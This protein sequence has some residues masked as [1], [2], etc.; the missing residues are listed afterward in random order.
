MK[1]VVLIWMM[2]L[3][4]VSMVAQKTYHIKNFGQTD[5][6][7]VRGSTC[8]LQFNGFMWVGTS[9]GLIGFDGKHTYVYTIPDKEG[10]GGYYS[11]VTA[12]AG[13]KGRRDRFWVGTKRG[14]YSFMLITQKMEPLV[15]QGAPKLASVTTMQFDA[16]GNLW[17]ILN[18]QAYMIDV[19][20][21]KASP[22]AEGLIAPSCL[23][24]TQNGT[25]WM[26]DNKGILYRYDSANRRLRSYNVKPEG[27]EKFER[28]NKITE[29]GNGKL[30]LLSANDGVCLF[31][32]EKF[33][34]KLLLTHDD[35]GTPITGHTAITPDGENLW[36]GSE[37]GIIIY[38]TK[39]GEVT[40]IRKS[41]KDMNS[42][43]GNAVHSLYL[44]DEKGVW[45]GTYF[46]G[47][48]RI[49]LSPQ[50][51]SVY[52]PEGE[53]PDVNVIRE[54][55]Y[56]NQ[57]NLWV[58][59]ED[60]GL[61][62]F[63]REKEKLRIA[64]VAWGGNPL[65]FNV[66][67]L[68]VVGDDLWV[69]SMMNGVYIID[70]RTM[71]VKNRLT[72]TNKTSVGMAIGFNSMCCQD[73]TIFLS[74]AGNGIYIYNEK[75]ES[76]NLLPETAG[77]Y[78]HHL[79]SDRHGNVWLTTF[80]KGLWKIQKKHGKW[81]AEQTPFSYKSTT[82]VIEDARGLFWVGTD[83]HGL[84]SYDDKT[85]TT[86]QMVLSERLSHQSITT[87]VE[88][89]HHRLW[90]GTFDG[91][92]SYNI[93]KKVV[94]HSG[95]VNGLPSVY[96]N[97]SAGC[98]DKDGSV[99][100]GTY[101]G[102]IHFDP[103]QFFLSRERLQPYFIALEVNGKLVM[104]GDSTH[105]LTETVYMTKELKLKHDQNTF[106][107]TYAV[108]SYRN[109]TVVWYRY[110]LNPDEPWI[111]VDDAQPIQLTNLSTGKY[112]ITLQASYNPEIWEGPTA[113][114]FV[115]VAPPAWLSPGAILGYVMGIVFVVVF[116]MSLINQGGK[117]F[118]RLKEKKRKAQQSA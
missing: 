72:K 25:V 39:D 47:M 75:E 46:G 87:I 9:T 76:F 113:S 58:G 7:Q 84:M 63:D 69:S 3:S 5:E 48:N 28:L 68:L 51:F 65:P 20:Q 37:R 10:L 2:V 110:R 11:R 98:L 18:G 105:L 85:G 36:I 77:T 111:I 71:Q 116:A 70:T 57:G 43:S 80:D 60:G 108:G 67:A 73:G 93:D 78:T 106:T 32:P 91:L 44:D 15:L 90:L 54:I 62:L 59:A 92:Y 64:N 94:N 56:D 1:K 17:A 31:S 107:L 16:E 95:I 30:A 103:M 12:L 100:M 41:R 29:M 89:K 13:E 66:Q 50:N 45:A 79:Y 14:I 34:S 112:K 82:V 83:L 27:V 22:I 8:L 24:V 114:I 74:S 23:T 61:Y 38:N 115:T 88:D 53:G 26:G 97:Y 109:G 55:C 81:V 99:F 33:T 86:E 96:L 104:P 40:G 35:E 101:Q 6:L 52:M 102:M 42:L 21:K 118:A 19:E 4:A 49:S 117:Q